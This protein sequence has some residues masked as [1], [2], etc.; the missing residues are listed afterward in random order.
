MD[1][2]TRDP[3]TGRYRSTGRTPD[4]CSVEGCERLSKARGWCIP[5]YHMWQ[6]HGDP[7]WK[8]EKPPCS[9]E[10]C[11]TPSDSL[12]LCKKHYDQNFYRSRREQV[13]E[14]SHRYYHEHREHCLERQKGWV[15]RNRKKRDEIFL[16]YR[17]KK[18]NAK[19]SYTIDEWIAL[20]AKYGN[21]CL[22]C[23]LGFQLHADHVIPLSK[24]GTNDIGNIQPLCRSCNSHKHTKSTDY[25][26]S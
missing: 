22:R 16:R 5:H 19:G 11:S 2:R 23:G 4:P 20:C 17:A 24:G 21:R 26:T 1:S 25:R 14:Q 8:K 7:A 3:Q 10:D 15:A 12:S 9:I 13:L 6:R 18:A